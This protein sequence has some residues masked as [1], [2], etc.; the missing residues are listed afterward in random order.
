M[1]ANCP[2]WVLLD[3]ALLRLGAV[4]AGLEPH[5]FEPGPRLLAEYGLKLLFTDGPADGPGVLPV[6]EA[7]RLA[8]RPGPARP[9][10]P[11]HYGPAEPT[12]LKFTSG[13]TGRPKALAATAGSVDS[14]LRA[15]QQMFAHG[16][17][18]DLF[19]FLPLS[20]LQQR[21][22]IYSALCFGHDVTVSTYE[23]AFPALS[24]ARPTVVMGVPAF[25]EAARTHITGQAGD[26]G[27]KGVAAAARR[28]FGD[29]VRYLWTGSAPASRSTLDFFDGLGMPLYEG[30]GL[31]ETCI[32]AKNH[33]G[34]HRPGSVGRVVPGKEVLFDEDGVI[35]IR[36]T[37]PVAYRYAYAP[38]GESER[39]FGP[40]GLVRTGD[41]G[42]LDEDG[43]LWIAG[44]ADDAVVLDNGR[45]IL[46]RPLEEFL[47]NSPAVEECVVFCVH[48]TR[49]VAVVAPS[50]EVPDE[51]AI[52][53]RLAEAREVFADDERISKAVVAADGFSIANGLLTSQFKPRRRRILAAF[54]AEIDDPSGGLH[55]T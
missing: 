45:K 26:A 18:D 36:S 24:Q 8:D 17:G 28:L 39:T 3:L 43:F 54:Q 16:P 40:D 35:S 14:S 32:V 23:A 34:A 38:P 47:R 25:Y 20:L 41:V 29:R 55:A 9:V 37:R 33:P 31:N 51:R 13:S 15:V 48:Q 4:T 53:R 5:K 7:G 21:Y 1:A 22:W 46:V 49:L 44:R 27:P 12:A 50:G 2:E 30:Y 42:R 10:P 52:V 6:S 11:A 19:V